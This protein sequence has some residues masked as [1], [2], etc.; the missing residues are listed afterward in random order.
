MAETQTLDAFGIGGFCSVRPPAGA[1]ED[2]FG[3]VGAADVDRLTVSETLGTDLLLEHGESDLYGYWE[4][5]GTDLL[6]DHGE[7]DLY[8]YWEA[9][10]SDLIVD[11]GAVDLYGYWEALGVDLILEHGETDTY[12]PSPKGTKSYYL[13][14]G[15]A[16]Y[17]DGGAKTYALT[18]GEK[19]YDP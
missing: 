7:T 11:H 2:Y 15:M 9:V 19:T 3:I 4:A 18:G 17:I 6:L 16:T 12:T 13:A 14:G 5:V 1:Y 8:G 10:G